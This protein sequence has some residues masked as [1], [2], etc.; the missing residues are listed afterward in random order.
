MSKSNW[1]PDEK[2]TGNFSNDKQDTFDPGKRYIG[3]RLQQGVPL[4]DRDWNELE[5]MRRHAEVVLRRYYIGNGTPDDGFKVSLIDAA[6]LDFRISSG[7]CLVNGF[8][9]VNGPYDESGNKLDFILYSKQEGIAPLTFG[10]EGRW[11]TVYLDVWV[12]EVSKDQDSGLGNSR[13]IDMETSRRHKLEW[14]V[15]VDEGSQGYE[16]QPFH[17]YYDL[18][19]INWRSAVEA[20]EKGVEDLRVTGLA[21]YSINASVKAKGVTNGD[22]HAHTVGDGAQIKH[23]SLNKDDG[24][25]PHAATAADVGALPITGGNIKGNL[26]ITGNVGIG[27]TNPL[28]VI[29]NGS[30]KHSLET[31]GWILARGNGENTWG[32][33]SSRIGVMKAGGSDNDAWWISANPNNTFAIHQGGVGDR[34]TID[35]NGKVGIGT[36]TPQKNVHIQGTSGGPLC[37]DGNDRPGLAITGHYPQLDLFSAI[38]NP[39]HGPTIRM[40]GYNDDSQTTFK[41][42]SIGTSA[43]NSSFLDFGVGPNN[44][45]NP[46]A[47][48]RNHNGRTVMT[49]LENGNVGIGTTA[50]SRKLEVNGDIQMSAPNTEGIYGI[51]L[52]RKDEDNRL[53]TWKFWHMNRGYGQ[54]SLQLWEYKTDSTGTSCDGN[55]KDGAMCDPRVTVAVG[56]N[57]G[58]GTTNPTRKLEVAGDISFGSACTLYNPGRMHIHGEELLYLLNKGGVV[59]SRAW[60]GSGNLT[61]EGGFFH[62]SDI[63]LKK[64]IQ[65][66]GSSLAKFSSLRGVRFKWKN[67]GK[68][69]SYKIGLIAQEVEPFFPELVEVGPNGMKSLNYVGLIPP[70]I[71]AVK[72][73]QEKIE[74]LIGAAKGNDFAEYF[75]SKSGKVIKP[76]TSIVLDEGKIRPAKENEIPMGIISANPG[77]LGGMYMEW[78]KKY[79]RDEF[80]NQIMEEYKEEIMAPKKEKVKRERQ[81]MEKKKVKENVTRTEIVKIKGK[82]CQKEVIDTIEREIEEPVFKEMDLYDAEGKKV[83]GKHRIPV[84][85][86]YEEEI[87]VLDK[88]G[89][90]VMVGTGKFETKTRPKINPD[91]DETKEY[92]S[93]EKRPEWNCVGL[94][95]Q[96]SL[97]KGQPVADTWIKIKDIS[98]EVELWLVK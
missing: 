91:Y 7:R 52:L 29:G 3:I 4:L 23:S 69:D 90:P 94:L 97:R 33:P 98:N 41:H 72:E 78:P 13:D 43:R 32:D 24:R 39:N 20:L 61:V 10:T 83:I 70:L 38:N 68:D 77:I 49:L 42:W 92:I 48:I 28:S 50:P 88:T 25:N 64:D 44:D 36:A 84:M 19:R 79:L 1:L 9:V 34:L 30:L 82:Y 55:V 66:L 45:A 14:R 71:E 60:G 75:E 40:G 26:A 6:T 47:G 11:D 74:G 31:T 81:K 95:G 65:P 5:D 80:G 51:E 96:L 73:Q 46:H 2:Q 8:D 53:H 18:A 54:N 86:T 67:P 22:N 21:L 93:R 87:D 76:G 63:S 58:I 12:E 57:V 16:K 35:S 89:Q 15:R 27:T 59:V 56:G 85:E 62:T 17:H 37:N